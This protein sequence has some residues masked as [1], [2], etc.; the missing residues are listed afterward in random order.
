MRFYVKRGQRDAMTP[1]LLLPVLAPLLLLGCSSRG[2]SVFLFPAEFQAQQVVRVRTQEKSK[3]TEAQANEAPAKHARAKTREETFVAVLSRSQDLTRVTLL[4][5]L[6]LAPLVMLEKKGDEVHTRWIVP[7]P[8]GVKGRDFPQK[9]MALLE[10]LYRDATWRFETTA[11]Q[12][13]NLS[14]GSLATTDSIFYSA[15]LAGF[16]PSSEGG[17]VFPRVIEVFPKQWAASQIRV[18]TSSVSCGA[19][20]VS[21]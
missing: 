19:E 1:W 9:L 15:T 10:D 18:E 20:R 7:E 13:S 17:C 6:F 14:K 3:T 8:D 16:N 12:P 11:V 2:P 4:D 21:Q 5:P